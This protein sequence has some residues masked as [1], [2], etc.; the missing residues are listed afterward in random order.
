MPRSSDSEGSVR[1]GVEELVRNVADWLVTIL[2]NKIGIIL[3]AAIAAGI[4]VI[5][6]TVGRGE[7]IRAIIFFLIPAAWGAFALSSLDGQPKAFARLSKNALPGLGVVA[8][9]LISSVIV[10]DAPVASTNLAL[11]A[12]EAFFFMMYVSSQPS[13]RSR[14]IPEG[15]HVWALSLLLMVTVVS[16]TVAATA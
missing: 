8:G 1:Q 11:G 5:S 14:A 7:G 10:F 16:V 6:F 2:Y 9:V 4:T 15:Q 3:I 13:G 12:M